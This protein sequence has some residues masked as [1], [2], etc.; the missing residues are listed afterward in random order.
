MKKQIQAFAVSLLAASAAS[1]QQ[2]VQWRVEDGG[3]GHW[4]RQLDFGGGVLYPF[5]K[6]QCVQQ[7]GHPV[8][9]TTPEEHAFVCSVMTVFLNWMGAER[10]DAGWTWCTGEDW[11]YGSICSP[12]PGADRIQFYGCSCW[13]DTF[14][15]D[16]CTGAVIVEWSADCNG[17]GIVDYGQCRDGSLADFDSDNVP[18]C[19]ERGEPCVVG[20]YPV[21]W[22]TAT[23]GN[24]H[25][26]QAVASDDATWNTADGGC[27]AVG[28]GLVSINSAAE[29]ALVK[30]VYRASGV[31]GH[32]WTGGWKPEGQAQWEWR[33]GEAWDYVAWGGT[34]CPSGPYPNNPQ[35]ELLAL[36]VS[37]A[38]GVVWDDYSPVSAKSL[39]FSG[40]IVEWSADCNNDGVVDCGQVLSGQ[41]DDFNRNGVPDRICDCIGDLTGDRVVNGSDLGVMLADWGTASG[42]RPSDLDASGSVD[43]FDIA[44]LL[45]NWGSCN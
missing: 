31:N 16:C 26:Y 34:G 1:A 25:W 35:S 44:H 5:A 8:T 10:V 3:N 43:G 38:C 32:M 29:W 39:D 37:E 12:T 6:A 15:D 42:P 22:P 23:G 13:N 14:D 21:Q 11:T 18:D 33:S 40:W 41:F 7:G 17:D 36:G 20:A 28:G 2:A 9:V 24:G 30:S 27:Q 4:Y 19:C 45:A